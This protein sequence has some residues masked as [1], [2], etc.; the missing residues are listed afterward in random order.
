[1]EKE[2]FVGKLSAYCK[3][4]GI[5]IYRLS[6]ITGVNRVQLSNINKTDKYSIRFNT[7]MLIYNGTKKEFG[8]GL[9]PSMYLSK[10]KYQWL[11]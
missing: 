11:K 7:A 2:N 4:Q 9:K 6:Q 5:T 1:M 8:K 3:S 10:D